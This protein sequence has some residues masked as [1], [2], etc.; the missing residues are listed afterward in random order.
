MRYIVRSTAF[1]F[2]SSFRL[3][4]GRIY[5]VTPFLGDAEKLLFDLSANCY[6]EKQYFVNESWVACQEFGSRFISDFSSD[7]KGCS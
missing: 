7:I 6:I 4:T 3:A 2:A 1:F 5:L